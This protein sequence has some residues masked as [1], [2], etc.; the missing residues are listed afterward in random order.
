MM[1]EEELRFLILGAQREG[2]RVLT[3]LLAPHGV[4]PSQAEVLRCLADAGSLSLNVLGQRL[5][6][7]TG[8]PSRLVSSLVDRG[9]VHRHENPDDRRQVSLVLTDEGRRLEEK[10]R[11]VERQLHGWIGNRLDPSTIAMLSKGLRQLLEGSTAGN[12]VRE[13]SSAVQTKE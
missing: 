13:R 8:S 7:E 3:S 5:V 9:W 1:P 4:T 12:A 2:N 6:C 10:V 11:N